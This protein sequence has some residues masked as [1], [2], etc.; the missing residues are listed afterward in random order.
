MYRVDRADRVKLGWMSWAGCHGVAEQH[1]LDD[2]GLDVAR[3]A[4][5]QGA[6]G[7]WD[8]DQMK[9]GTMDSV[10][11]GFCRG[12]LF[13]KSLP[14]LLCSART[15]LIRILRLRSVGRHFRLAAQA[16]G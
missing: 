15:V 14:L 13:L 3:W 8:C 2:S 1:W 10:V 16:V 5:Q 6:T 12:P 7:I 11:C 9:R 4:R